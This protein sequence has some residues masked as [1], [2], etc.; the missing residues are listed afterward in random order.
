MAPHPTI[1]PTDEQPQDDLRAQLAAM[2]EQ[3]LAMQANSAP[4]WLETMLARVTKASSQ[5]SELLAS[6]MR[7]ENSDHL[8][9]GPFEHAEGGLKFPKEYRHTDGH[10]SD[11]HRPEIVYAG[12]ILRTDEVT[13]QEWKAANALSE[14]LGRGQRRIARDG[15]WSAV[16]NDGDTRLHISVPMKTMDDRHDLPSFLVICQELTT[17]ARQKDPSE[18]AEEV[19]K[20]R[21]EVARL[22][23][24]AA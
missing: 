20:L 9:L 15:K 16:V 21:D 22:T 1:K 8:H 10:V 17:G 18:L 4:P 14:S 7:P 13:Y 11:F 12:R 6:K 23:K 5:A 3:L 2:Q 19:A 24:A